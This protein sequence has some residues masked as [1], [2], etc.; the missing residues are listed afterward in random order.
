MILGAVLAF[1]GGLLGFF[2]QWWWNRNIQRKVVL[3]FLQELLRAY[4]RVA[5]RIVETYEK[6]GV[7]WNDLLNQVSNDLALYERNCEHSILLPDLSIRAA[8]WD[9]F[10]SLRTVVNM[11]LGLNSMLLTNPGNQWAKEE[12]KKQVERIKELRAEAQRLLEK[13]R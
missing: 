7:L 3:E 9:W 10:S 1:G 13:L 2:I 6:S 11:S 4:D 12:V 5:P 8:V